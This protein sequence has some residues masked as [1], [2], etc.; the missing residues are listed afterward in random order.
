MPKIG[1]WD[2]VGRSECLLGRQPAK[3][4]VSLHNDHNAW[5]G[6]E[7]HYRPGETESDSNNHH[8]VYATAR[9]SAPWAVALCIWDSPDKSWRAKLWNPSFRYWENKLKPNCTSM[10]SAFGLWALNRC[11]ASN[12]ARNLDGPVFGTGRRNELRSMHLLISRDDDD[13]HCIYIYLA[14]IHGKYLAT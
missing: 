1:R 8:R 14:P 5:Q 2:R 4:K 13:G 9:R 3:W 12:E 10:R 6:R 11:V 7:P